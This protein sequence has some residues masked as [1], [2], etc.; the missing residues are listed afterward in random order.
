MRIISYVATLATTGIYLGIAL[1]QT[2]TGVVL[3]I[4]LKDYVFYQIETSDYGQLAMDPGMPVANPPRTF[5]SFA[6]I[7]DIVAVNGRAVKG[8]FVDRANWMNPK[9]NP[10]PGQ[11][12]ADTNRAPFVQ[13]HC[14]ILQEDGTPVGSIAGIGLNG[15]PAPPGAPSGST[16]GTWIV[17]GGTGAFLGVRGQG[18]FGAA[19]V[20]LDARRSAVEDP[21]NRRLHGGA[22]LPLI[23]YLIP[24][25]RPEIV[26]TSNGPAVVHASDFTPVTAAT[27]ARSGEALTLFAS[28]L[29]PTRPGVDP[30]LP[31]TADPVQV[32]NSPLDVIVNGR[33]AEVLYA[34][35]YPGAVDRYQV[36]FT[37]PD[38]T[39]A[40]LA[41][42]QLSSAWI[43]GP[44][45]RIAVQ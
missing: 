33:S 24:M 22:A 13:W 28:G 42:V 20:A 25:S 1:A 43:V 4:D 19:T 10:R 41:V 35:G 8:T 2:P 18:A 14:E 34:G 16:G 6:G 5:G 39:E 45:V 32:V 15:G 40:G 3:K 7:A 37:V 23:L 27:P 26:T 38:G 44:E 31:F 30:G 36:N 11:A 17:T 12:I 9:P 21:V 29:G